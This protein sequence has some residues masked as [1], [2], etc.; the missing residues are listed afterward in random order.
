MTAAPHQNLAAPPAPA[1]GSLLQLHAPALGGLE[2]RLRGVLADAINQPGSLFRLRLVLALGRAQNVD[3]EIAGRLATAVEF[4]HTASLLLDD[5]PC[6]DDATTRRGRPCAHRLHGEAATILGA[7]ALINRSYALVA[8]ATVAL[9]FHLRTETTET[10]DACLGC[11]GL[12][13]GQ[14]RDLAFADTPPSPRAVGRAAMGKTAAML[15]LALELPAIAAGASPL[16]RR[17]LRRLAVYW[18]LLY[19][20]LDDLRD[21]RLSAATG[22]PKTDGRDSALGRPNLALATGLPLARARLQHLEKLA[23][24]AVRELVACGRFWSVLQLFHRQLSAPLDSV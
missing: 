5:L 8:E 2:P 1:P 3:E 13:A 12:V 22:A 4:Y 19:Q 17:Q 20:G 6:M 10:L 7:L 16:E 14:A 18:G 11:A 21:L 24:G 15:R 9:P 23:A